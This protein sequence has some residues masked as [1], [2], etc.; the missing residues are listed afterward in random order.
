MHGATG[1]ACVTGFAAGSA[2]IVRDE[3]WLV[4]AVEPVGGAGEDWKLRCLGTSEFVRGQVGTFY[5]DLDRIDP[6]EPSETCLRIDDSPR[7][8]RSR[9]WVEAML[10]KTPVALH[11]RSLVVSDDM[12]LDPLGY[13]R[14]AVRAAL[15]PDRLQPRLLIADAVGLGKTL[16]IGMIL[17]EL[18]RRGRADR[19]LVV[20]PRHVL[21][22][23]QYELWTR[24]ALPLVRLDSAG[25]AKVRRELPASR[26]PFTAFPK[27]IVS[28]DTLKSRRYRTHLES[29]RWDAVVIDESHNVTGSTTRN[30]RL[31]RALA[32]NTEALVLASATPH[33]GRAH[34]FAQLVELLDPTAVVDRDEVSLADTAHLF[35]RR[36]RHSEEVARE[37]W[38]SWAERPEPQ[39]LV[40]TANPEE[41]AVAGE[42]S[43]AWL[44]APGGP[45]GGGR[46][47]TLFGWT[48]AKAFLSSREALRQTIAARRSRLETATTDGRAEDDALARLDALAAAC[49]A[50]SKLDALT[51]HCAAI[52]VPEGT[53]VV[54]FAER[55]ATQRAIA[56]GL[57]RR[58]GLPAGAVD[59]LDGGMLDTA[60]QALVERFQLASSPVRVLVATDVASEGVNLHRQCHHLVHADIPWSLIR[61]E[62]R[63]G[64]I[65]RYG[66]TEEPTIRALALTLADPDFSGDVRVLTRLLRK[67]HLAH[68][69]LGESAS[70]LDLH[71][72]ELEEGAV[73]DAL[74]AGRPLDDV[75]P[76]AAGD[77]GGWG[78]WA[79]SFGVSFAT[80]PGAGEDAPEE[81]GEDEDRGDERLFDDDADFLETALEEA[82][83]EAHARPLAHGGVG[84]ERHDDVALLTPPPDL[85]TRLKALPQSYRA[86]RGVD[87]RLTLATTRAAG[88]R[89]LA[90][91]RE[92]SAST[93]LWPDAHYLG[94][95]HPVLDWAADRAL[96][97]M[98]RGEAPVAAARVDAPTAVMLGT[99]ANRRGQVVL[100]TLVALE[101]APNQA[102]PLVSDDVPDLLRAAGLDGAGANSGRAGV[103]DLAVAQELVP[104]AVAAMRDYMATQK[105]MRRDVMGEPL[106]AAARRIRRWRDDVEALAVRSTPSEA[107]RLRENVARSGARAEELT[108]SLSARPDPHVALLLVLVPAKDHETDRETP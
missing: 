3:E 85:R 24:F 72:V 93:L 62:Q 13:Q 84:W 74:I 43:R 14:S 102:A 70:L 69:A 37:V 63:N 31:A 105:E 81:P 54:V 87:T 66:Q 77:P 30:N 64:R 10:R 68:R 59:T 88:E 49:T 61:I 92:H 79:A 40:V 7:F 50:S 89:S 55:L 35:V 6:Y 96:A 9:L 12:L 15:A 48:L 8:R 101:F 11:E 34:S 32:P 104:R 38:R 1:G 25:I 36:H 27:V 45:P 53:R 47:R 95:L 28:I 100:R 90:S 4:T 23:M 5:T 46:G 16:E 106:R 29:H 60:Q 76:D 82:F 39:A 97:V 78:D 56:E 99:L 80:T 65:D 33:N 103:A 58:L 44:H 57:T 20:T 94:P 19:V 42:L 73:R 21:E 98:D 17:A 18:Q 41:D 67:E 22:Q 107:A 26:N 108:A 51:E 86:A 71:D 52:G 75:V 83:D 2:V 91:A